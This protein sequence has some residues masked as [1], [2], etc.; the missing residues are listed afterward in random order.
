MADL[1]VVTKAIHPDSPNGSGFVYTVECPGRPSCDGFIECDEKHEID[2]V[3]AYEGP[4]DCDEGVPWAE[5]EVFEFHGVPH[6]WHDGYG[7]SVPYVGCVVR[8]HPYLAEIADDLLCE[9][10]P[11]RYPVRDHWGY[12]EMELTLAEATK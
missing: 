12:E 2:G 5:L 4:W 7:W 9:S 8:A 6:T 10:P 11:G 1:H 3:N